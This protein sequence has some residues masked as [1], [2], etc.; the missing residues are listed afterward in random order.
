MIR[1]ERVPELGQEP[2]L[3]LALADARIAWVL[4]HP[5]ISDWLK[6]S[7]RLADELDPIVLQS[8]VEMLKHLIMLRSQARIE[9]GMSP[10]RLP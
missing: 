9:I 8:D 10:V 6:Q 2:E 7:L 1:E 5:H 4:E 3:M